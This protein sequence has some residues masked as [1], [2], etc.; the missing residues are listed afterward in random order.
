MKIPAR[1]TP[2]LIAARGKEREDRQNLIDL[3]LKRVGSQGTLY[4]TNGHMALAI[5]VEELTDEDLGGSVP[6]EAVQAVEAHRDGEFQPTMTLGP[7]DVIVDLSLSPKQTLIARREE[8]LFP[9]IETTIRYIVEKKA[10]VQVALNVK[11][12]ARLAKAMGTQALILTLHDREGK[13]G[14]GVRRFTREADPEGPKATA[15]IMPIRVDDDPVPPWKGG[16]PAEPEEEEPAFVVCPDPGCG[17]E[18]AD[19]GHN[20]S[21]EECGAGPMPTSVVPDLPTKPTV[22]DE[23]R[24]SKCGKVAPSVMTMSVNGGE[25]TPPICTPCLNKITKSL[26]KGKRP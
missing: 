10:I 11:Y 4:A 18:Q 15:V 23:S 12:L 1:Y 8:Q 13:L 9:D 14:V 24:C 22:Q 7:S 19:M 6:V 5:D 25:E 17:H 21:C 2:S 16:Q 26:A 20:V 3:C